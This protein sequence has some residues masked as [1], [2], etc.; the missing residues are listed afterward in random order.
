MK[1]NDNLAEAFAGESQANRKYLAFAEAAAKDGLPEIAKLFRAV[2]AAETI[3]AHAHLRAMGGVKATAE[4]LRAAISGEKH[5]FEEM[6]PA[7]V[8]TAEAEGARLA[9]LSMRHALEVEKIHHGLFTDALAA[10][11]AGHDLP[12]GAIHVCAI[13]GH[14]V[15]GEVPDQCPVCHA[16]AGKFSEVA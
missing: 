15:I 2:A 3:H 11:E 5:E 6:Y 1:T 10:V 8:A 14:T 7:F 13:C 4:N 16:K 12:E 9:L